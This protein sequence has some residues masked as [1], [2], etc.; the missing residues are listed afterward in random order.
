M[1]RHNAPCLV[2]DRTDAAN[3]RCD[4]CHPKPEAVLREQF[5]R[6]P[7]WNQPHVTSASVRRPGFLLRSPQS[8]Y[9][10]ADLLPSSGVTIAPLTLP[11]SSTV[12]E[13]RVL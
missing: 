2:C 5:A 7:T 8:V 12:K 6:R 13:R 1:L 3:A 9:A 10:G 4:T 11:P